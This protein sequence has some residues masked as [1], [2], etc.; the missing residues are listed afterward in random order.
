MIGVKLQGRLG[1]QMFQYAFALGSSIN[2]KTKYFIVPEKG[3]PFI[4]PAYFTLRNYSSFVNYFRKKR[5]LK[6]LPALDFDNNLMPQENLKTFKPDSLIHGYFQ[7]EEYFKEIS[8]TIREEFEIK[9]KYRNTFEEKFSLLFKENKVIAVHVRKDDYKNHGDESLGGKD[10]SLPLDYYLKCLS[11]IKDIDSYKVVFV[12]DDPDELKKN[13]PKQD[14]YLFESNFLMTDFQILNN[15]DILI[16]SNSSFSWW[17]AYLN[18]KAVKVFYPNYWLGF[19]IKK[20]YPVG[21]P[22]DHWEAVNVY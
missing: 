12:T 16:L 18:R 10:L 20:F 5:F 4:L 13:F 15:A 19:K 1:N 21:I 3:T 11:E 17:G 22:L 14:N 8:Q 6:G 9:K 2:K 7:S